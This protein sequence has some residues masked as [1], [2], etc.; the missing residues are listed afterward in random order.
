VALESRDARTSRAATCHGVPKEATADQA[1]P[2]L[3]SAATVTRPR[4]AQTR[5]GPT[6]SEYECSCESG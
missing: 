1:R 6:V 5:L 2:V 3:L 4:S